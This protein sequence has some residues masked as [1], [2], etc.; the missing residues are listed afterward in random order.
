MLRW[1]IGVSLQYRSVVL[2]WAAIL[3]LLGLYRLRDAPVN[4]LPELSPTLVEIQTEAPGLSAGEVEDL[5]TVNTEEL[6]ANTP[7]VKTVRSKSVPGM[8]SVLLLFEDGTDMM[9]ARQ[10]VQERLIGA[11][12][13]PNV[14]KRPVMLQPL[15]TASRAIIIGL[16]SNEKSLIDLSVLTTSRVRS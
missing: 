15:S 12:A 4:V 6:L 2:A 8:S 16:S 11:Y 5:I 3:F 13:L 14:S 10:V 7:W 1:L 9:R